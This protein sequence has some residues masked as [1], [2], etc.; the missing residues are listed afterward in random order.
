[1]QLRALNGSEKVEIGMIHYGIGVAA[2]V[3]TFGLWL[4]RAYQKAAADGE[5]TLDEII[6]I[7]TEAVG[8]VEEAVKTVEELESMKKADLQDLLRYHGLPTSGNK[9][10]LIARLREKVE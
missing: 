10:E 8:R 3:G 6:D 2:V 7:A 5:V 1:V 4:Y 9:A